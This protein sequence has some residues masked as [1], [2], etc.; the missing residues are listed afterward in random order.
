[1]LATDEDAVICDLAETYGIFDYRSL[2]IC[3]VAT[4]ASG[5]KGDSRI[6][7][8]M[9]GQKNTTEQILLAGI[10]DRLSW[11]AWTKTKDAQK[12]YNRPASVLEKMLGETISQQ[13]Q[14]EVY[15][16]GEDFINRLSQLR[17]NQS[18]QN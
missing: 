17:G 14:F 1:M 18:C 9:S 6:M 7:Q 4:L 10:L 3:T 2:P 12:G 8:K 16:T 11:I 15:E 13:N 5:L